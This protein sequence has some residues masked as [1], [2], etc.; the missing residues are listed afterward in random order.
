MLFGVGEQHLGN[1]ALGRTYAS[2]EILLGLTKLGINPNEVLPDKALF[3]DYNPQYA[4]RRN[5]KE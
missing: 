4:A 1:V 5:E 2:T 3:G